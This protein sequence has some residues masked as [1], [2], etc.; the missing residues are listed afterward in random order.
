MRVVMNCG[1]TRLRVECVNV[2]IPTYP[3]WAFALIE[4]GLFV[5]LVG[6]MI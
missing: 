1:A 5:I 2:A 4:I 3:R 6:V